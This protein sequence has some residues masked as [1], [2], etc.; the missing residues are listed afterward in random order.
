MGLLC[1]VSFG[2]SHSCGTIVLYPPR[3][4]LVCSWTDDLGQF[5]QCEFTFQ[6]KL[7]CGLC[8]CAKSES[9]PG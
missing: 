3:L 1:V 8:L 6:T 2:S 7:S 4:S 5:V 9:C